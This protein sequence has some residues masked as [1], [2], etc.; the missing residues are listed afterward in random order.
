LTTQPKASPSAGEYYA[1][2]ENRM[3]LSGGKV[4][5]VAIYARGKSELLAT[6]DCVEKAVKIVRS[7]NN[8]D[9]LLAALRLL[10]DETADYI[11]INNL[12]DPHH[13]RSMQMARDAIARAEGEGHDA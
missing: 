5:K 11:T 4:T 3:F 10:H 2:V 7:V 9:T 8:F 12:G 6:C 1:S 13:N